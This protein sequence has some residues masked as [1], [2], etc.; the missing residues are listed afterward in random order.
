M[1][2]DQKISPHATQWRAITGTAMYLVEGATKL[3][4]K[5]KPNP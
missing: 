3:P 4:P 1:S 2:A 5:K